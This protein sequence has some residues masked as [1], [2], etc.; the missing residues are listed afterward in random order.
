MPFSLHIN[1]CRGWWWMDSHF[2]RFVLLTVTIRNGY[3]LS[4]LYFC[5]QDFLRF[6]M[7][8]CH[9]LRS[10]LMNNRW[11][12][13][14]YWSLSFYT[15]KRSLVELRNYSVCLGLWRVHNIH[16]Q[17]LQRHCHT[18]SLQQTIWLFHPKVK[19]KINPS[20][21]LQG[22][23]HINAT[24]KNQISNIILD[25]VGDQSCFSMDASRFQIFRV[26]LL[27]RWHAIYVV[28]LAVL[29]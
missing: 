29:S 14:S 21:L 17:G 16:L 28:K 12:L 10:Q 15:L 1:M 2:M 26:W 18:W 4:T 9:L 8:F 13:T 27:C 11:L 5:H 22:H 24:G 6:Y 3:W 19:S 23:D 20:S 25:A 7:Q